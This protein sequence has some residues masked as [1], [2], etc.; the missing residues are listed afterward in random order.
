MTEPGWREI[1]GNSEG[2]TFDTN[3]LDL[4]KG[5]E[6]VVDL[7]QPDTTLG[8]MFF[9]K[10]KNVNKSTI[11][12]QTVGNYISTNIKIGGMFYPA[13]IR[14]IQGTSP[15]ILGRDFFTKFRWNSPSDNRIDTPNGVVCLKEEGDQLLIDE[16]MSV[17]SIQCEEVFLAEPTKAAQIKKLH[18][19]F[20]HCSSESLLRLINASSK[21]DQ[22]KPSE[23]KEICENCK[24]S[25]LTMRKVNKKKTSLPKATGFKG[26]RR[27]NLRLVGS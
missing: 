10:W 25:R 26:T 9:T 19:Y 18:A 2:K 4:L 21:K 15:V 7:L 13:E 1:G 11:V 17:N 22:F 8:Q 3:S 6:I 5:T 24:V 12:I 23:I 20:G 14:L 27:L 16:E